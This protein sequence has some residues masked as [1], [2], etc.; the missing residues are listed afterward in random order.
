M[1]RIVSPPGRKKTL[2]FSPAKRISNFPSLKWSLSKAFIWRRWDFCLLA[3]RWLSINGLLNETPCHLTHIIKKKKKRTCLAWVNMSADHV[4]RRSSFPMEITSRQRW[5]NA[6]QTLISFVLRR[7]G[8]EEKNRVYL[9]WNT[10]SRIGS[11]GRKRHSRRT[12]CWE[13]KKK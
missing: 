10:H 6:W 8:R 12:W 13:S 11:R 7:G 2:T 1:M 3:N 5:R 9:V 4:L